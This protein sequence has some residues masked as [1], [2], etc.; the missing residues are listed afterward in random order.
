M[1]EDKKPISLYVK[2]HP[3]DARK[4]LALCDKYG[5]ETRD[6]IRIGT[7]RYA[8]NILSHREAPPGQTLCELPPDLKKKRGG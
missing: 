3:D 8:D 7:M 4:V 6:F 1:T 2:L 5:V